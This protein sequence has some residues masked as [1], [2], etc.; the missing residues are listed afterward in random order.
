MS[1]FLAQI[2]LHKTY[3]SLLLIVV[4][5]VIGFIIPKFYQ[6]YYK[7]IKPDHN[8]NYVSGLGII[9]AVIFPL[10]YFPIPIDFDIIQLSVEVVIA[11]IIGFLCDIKTI[12]KRIGL[13][14]LC[15][16]YIIQAIIKLYW[17]KISWFDFTIE[18]FWSSIV[19]VSVMATSVVFEM[20]FIMA[21]IS[22]STFL[23][24]F[25]G[26]KATPPEAYLFTF[27][28][29]IPS[30]F[31]LFEW[32]ILHKMNITGSSGL[33]ALGALIARISMLGK[34]KTLLLFALL[35]PAMATLLPVLCISFIITSYLANEL[36]SDRFHKKNGFVPTNGT[37]SI[38]INNVD[39][40]SDAKSTTI[41]YHT[42]FL[43][44][45]MIVFY[46]SIIF[47]ILNFGT[48]LY[49]VKAPILVW[50]LFILLI[51]CTFTGFV[52]TFAKK[53]TINTDTLYRQGK[54]KLFDIPIDSI[55]YDQVI[56]KIE[57]LIDYKFNYDLDTNNNTILNNYINKVYHIVTIDSLALLR[58]IEDPKFKDLVLKADI[59]I[60]DGAGIIWA[61]D[62]LGRSLPQ[63]IPG[64]SLM[65][66]LCA[67]SASKEWKIYLLGAKPDVIE[68]TVIKLK[69]KFANI[70]IV[71]Y[72]HGYISENSKPCINDIINNIMNAKP[73]LLFVG[74]GVPKQEEFIDM[75]RHHYNLDKPLIAIGVGGSFDVIS[76]MLPRA[77]E[78]MQK[79]ALEWLYRLWLEP[80]RINRIIKIPKFVNKVL[81]AKIQNF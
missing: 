37:N 30:L 40:K 35:F 62:F 32:L 4:G 27:S 28:Q 41:K 21:L 78:I 12:K 67:I 26:Q 36:Y 81:K 31:I 20:P 25:Q 13:L 50:I 79:F 33:M 10:L 2:N 22:G 49:V 11:S 5:S 6:K 46:T 77:P 45:E 38:Y 52:R 54:I 51:F 70:N 16:L 48:L 73:D 66:D 55:T 43:N 44:R 63:R 17:L 18:C 24:F 53:V 58:T 61:A 39:T 15:I 56:R 72:H 7:F 64:V 34:S 76:G 69:Q 80:S 29:I 23:L 65:Q 75:L 68:Q 14:L 1:V 8:T 71:G 59:V 42:W 9:L 3:I 74:M 57:D 19:I 47:I 60:P